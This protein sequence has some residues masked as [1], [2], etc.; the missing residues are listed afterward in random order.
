MPDRLGLLRKGAAAALLCAGAMWGAYTA[1]QTAAEQAFAQAVE[2]LRAALPPDVVLEHGAVAADPVSGRITVADVAFG[3]RADPQE[4]IRAPRVVLEGLRANGGGIGSLNAENITLTILDLGRPH[5]MAALGSLRATGLSLPERGQPFDPAAMLLD[6]LEAADISLT[7]VNRNR[8]PSGR[9]GRI[10]IA[11]IGGDRPDRIEI[12]GLDLRIPEL[13][14]GD[15]LRIGRAGAENMRALP[16]V[17]ALAAGTPPQPPPGVSRLSVEGL[18]V[19]DGSRAVLSVG[20]VASEGEAI[21]GSPTRLR[22][23]LSVEG[24]EIAIPP[25]LGP[26]S[27]GYSSIRASIGLAVEA[28]TAAGDWNLQEFRL[29]LPDVGTLELALQMTGLGADPAVDAMRTGRL[30]GFT[31]RYTDAGLV[32][33]A[34]EQ[35]AKQGGMRA[36]ELR[37]QI[38]EAAPMLFSG[39]GADGNVA[40]LRRFLER[41]G[42]IELTA[43]LPAPVRFSD[44]ERE[45]NAGPDRLLRLLNI[46]VTAR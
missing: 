8:E 26:F 3:P 18:S 2:R 46:G 4:R 40:A 33:R 42:T 17:L 6:S 9:I 25:E 12:E 21:G 24:V 41:P 1:A 22:G 16:L 28:E 44:L 43:R 29:A 10:A 5:R 20:R 31:L 7:P 38:V 19:Q 37:R 11:G 15:G 32:A 45:G 27:L 30:H 36:E 34:L 39:P 23:R 35:G 14:F 13:G